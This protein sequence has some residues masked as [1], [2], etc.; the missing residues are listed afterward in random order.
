LHN[1]GWTN[2]LD[3][4]PYGS[5]QKRRLKPVPGFPDLE[6]STDLHIPFRMELVLTPISCWL[7][8]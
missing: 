2:R 7:E 8:F 3:F 5:K 1:T 4:L 6:V